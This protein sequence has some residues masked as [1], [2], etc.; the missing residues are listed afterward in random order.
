VQFWQEVAPAR[1]A[2]NW[3]LTLEQGLQGVDWSNFK[4]YELAAQMAQPDLVG[5]AVPRVPP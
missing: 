5:A 1:G 4:A 3:E 2:T